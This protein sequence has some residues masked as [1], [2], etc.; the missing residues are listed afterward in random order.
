MK[1]GSEAGT[2]VWEFLHDA[3]L[4]SVALDWETRTATLVL[5]SGEEL[6]RRIEIRIEGLELLHC[7]RREPWGHGGA[8]LVN[9]M[10]QYQRVD[11]VALLTVEMQSGD[12]IRIEARH[13]DLNAS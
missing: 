2:V 6:S 8:L 12:E 10:R 4:R 5:D 11:G 9:D 1:Q 7:P 3:I 13:I